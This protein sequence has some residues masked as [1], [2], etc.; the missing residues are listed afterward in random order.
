LK[1]ITLRSARSSVRP[2]KK[3][4]TPAAARYRQSGN[5]AARV[6]IRTSLVMPRQ[7][8]DRREH[9]N[10]EQIELRPHTRQ[11]SAEAEYER[12]AAA[13]S[14]HQPHSTWTGARR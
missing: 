13:M 10:A 12:P 14:A 6:P 3:Q 2:A 8:D 1:T 7:P 11:P 4:N 9:H 5:V